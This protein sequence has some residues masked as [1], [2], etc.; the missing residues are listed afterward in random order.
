VVG[1]R[2][3]ICPAAERY[4][5]DSCSCALGEAEAEDAFDLACG[6]VL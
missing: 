2:V 4:R 1:K 3:S 6:S 5:Q